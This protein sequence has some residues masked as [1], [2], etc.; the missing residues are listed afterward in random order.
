LP[1]QRAVASSSAASTTWSD[2]KLIQLI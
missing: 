2:L 1:A